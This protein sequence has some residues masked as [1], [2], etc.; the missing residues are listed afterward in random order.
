MSVSNLPVTVYAFDQHQ[1]FEAARVNLSRAHLG[2][3][4]IFGSG[5]RGLTSGQHRHLGVAVPELQILERLQLGSEV[6]IRSADSFD[7]EMDRAALAGCYRAAL[8]ALHPP[9]VLDV[10]D[11]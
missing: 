1:R 10:P 5:V 3:D 8:S 4:E 2:L 9:D 7:N 6:A 11:A